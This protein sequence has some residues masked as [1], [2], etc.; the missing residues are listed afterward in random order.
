MTYNSKIVILTLYNREYETLL[1]NKHKY[2][3]EILDYI[4]N[5]HPTPNEMHDTPSRVKQYIKNLET[6]IVTH[7]LK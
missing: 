1:L 4:T 6:A 2:N 5:C 3:M 7:I